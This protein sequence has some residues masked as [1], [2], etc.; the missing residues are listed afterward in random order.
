MRRNT[1]QHSFDAY[2][3]VDFWPVNTDAFT[4]QAK[5]L[6]LLFARLAQ[7]P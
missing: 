1:M 2:V 7:S 3:L 5:I 4:D 6:S